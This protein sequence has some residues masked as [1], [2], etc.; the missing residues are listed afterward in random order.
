MGTLSSPPPRARTRVS[1]VGVSGYSGI[2][3]ARLVAAHPSFD[4]VAAYSDSWAASPLG[5][6]L[7]L[8]ARAAALVV[9]P[10]SALGNARA[11]D[12]VLLATPAE[13]SVELAPRLLAGG[14]RVIDL[15]GGFRLKD[16]A[17]YLRWY[18]FEHTAPELLPEAVYG[19]PELTGAVEK[20]AT[21][22]LVANP[23]CYATAAVVALAPLLAAGLVSPEAV[24][25]DGKSGATGAGK[26][27]DARLMFSE[28]AETVAPYRVGAHQHT[29]EIEQELSCLA[30]EPVQVTFTPHLLPI[31]RG[32]LVTAYGKLRDGVD[33]DALGPALARYYAERSEQVVVV[34]PGAVSIADV[35]RDTHALV[36]VHADAER[37]TF[38]AV[39]ALDNLLKGAASQAVQNLCWMI[40]APFAPCAT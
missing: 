1:I 29:P 30:G 24:F 34:A 27:V 6:H 16:P 40:G 35:Q 32:L 8:G 15:S 2:E 10:L 7:R 11:S 13:V 20:I 36:G 21:A 4:L 26:K 14:A 25:I 18:G 39:A 5:E 22:R 19:L 31:R 38:V 12:V 28:V 9:E 3:L 23:G 37:R 33:A 17:A